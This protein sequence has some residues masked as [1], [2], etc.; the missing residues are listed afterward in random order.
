M[1]DVAEELFCSWHATNPQLPLRR[2]AGRKAD[3]LVTVGRLL[4]LPLT[5]SLDCA[6][7]SRLRP[8]SKP[9]PTKWVLNFF[10]SRSGLQVLLSEEGS[11][12]SS[13]S[14]LFCSTSPAQTLGRND[15]RGLAFFHR[16]GA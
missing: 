5:R 7:R 12:L 11:P 15:E 9:S 16:A 1:L 14:H 4:L 6:H 2:S 10:G 13:T 3:C 8:P